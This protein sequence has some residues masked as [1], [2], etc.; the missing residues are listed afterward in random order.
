[1]ADFFRRGAETFFFARGATLRA[2][3]TSGFEFSGTIGRAE[4]LEN[5]AKSRFFFV[6]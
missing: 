2:G 6:N 4:E 3:G 1:M 5:A